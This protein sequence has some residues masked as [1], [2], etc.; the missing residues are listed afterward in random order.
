[1]EEGEGVEEIVFGGGKREE[2]EENEKTKK[3]CWSDDKR[4][5][6][7]Q[8]VLVSWK[9]VKRSGMSLCTAVI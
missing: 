4:R 2:D 3:P 6:E 9:Y 8:A 7:V 5:E 1:M